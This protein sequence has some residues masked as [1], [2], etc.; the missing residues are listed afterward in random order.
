MAPARTPLV[1]PAGPDGTRRRVREERASRPGRHTA[2]RRRV[3]RRVGSEPQAQHRAERVPAQ[4][5]P[6]GSSCGLGPR[7]RGQ[8]AERRPSPDAP[9]C[10]RAK[11]SA[12]SAHTARPLRSAAAHGSRL[13][14]NRSPGRVPPAGGHRARHRW[15]ARGNRCPAA[16]PVAVPRR[17][18]GRRGRRR[19]RGIP[20]GAPSRTRSAGGRRIEIPVAPSPRCRWG[21]LRPTRRESRCAVTLRASGAHAHTRRGRHRSHGPPA[22]PRA[23]PH[24]CRCMGGRDARR[25]FLARR[26]PRRV[27]PPGTRSP[28]DSGS[29]G[30]TWVGD[31]AAIP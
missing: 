31:A 23:Q 16:L 2:Q 10:R 18:H 13:R 28:C 3:L 17:R 21:L 20:R 30:S 27:Q 12:R 8:R 15:H 6:A 26:R 25:G 7:T 22:V 11:P 14:R 24:R 29:F 1:L 4:S 19:S 5:Y 9:R